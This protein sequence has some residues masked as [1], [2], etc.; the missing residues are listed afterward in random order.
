MGSTYHSLHYHVVFSTKERVPS[1]R[2]E[3]GERVHAY[4]GGII[5]NQ[6]GV[7][8]A[9]GGVEDHVHLLLGLK[10]THWIADVTR[11]LK[12]D[13]SNWITETFERNFAWQEGYAVFT[14]SASNVEAV[15]AYIGR[16]EEHHRK[17]GF[18]DELRALLEKHGV[19]FE[20]KYPA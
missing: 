9:V 7:P 12:K 16:Q 19:N 18:L 6:G 2:P 15:R 20:G 11:D 14:V 8:E 4:L 1:L 13:S 10:T 5:R 17:A 3:W